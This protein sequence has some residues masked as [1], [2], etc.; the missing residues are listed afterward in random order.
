MI[1]LKPETK[2]LIYHQPIDMRKAIDGLVMLIVD[3]LEGDPQNKTLYLF[4]NKS[5]DK[6]KGVVWDGDGFILLYKRREKGRFKF[7]KEPADD[8]YE[9]DPDLFEWLRKGFD[10]YALKQCPELK[11]TCYY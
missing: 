9:I 5:G 3:V 7:P 11:A 6:F 8:C 4:R 1:V 2:I 10:F